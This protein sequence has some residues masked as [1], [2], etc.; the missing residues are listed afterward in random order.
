[1][2]RLKIERFAKQLSSIEFVPTCQVFD[3]VLG[4]PR[5]LGHFGPDDK[6]FLRQAGP[7]CFLITLLIFQ[8]KSRADAHRMNRPTAARLLQ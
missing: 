5:V 2:R 7:S 6:A 4:Q 1:M 8:R 3:A